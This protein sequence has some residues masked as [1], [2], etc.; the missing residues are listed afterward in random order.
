MHM[1]SSEQLS[2]CELAAWRGFLRAP[3]ALVRELGAGRLDLLAS[4]E[5][6]PNYASTRTGSTKTKA[7][8]K[9]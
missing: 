2:A 5:L 7:K 6:G 9:K 8:S 1:Q 4:G 3:A